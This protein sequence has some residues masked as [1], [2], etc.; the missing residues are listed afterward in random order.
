MKSVYL[1]I[2]FP[3][4]SSYLRSSLERW[5]TLSSSHPP[6]KKDIRL[7]FEK[8]HRDITDVWRF[9]DPDDVGDILGG[10]GFFERPHIYCLIF[11]Q[12]LRSA[13]F[14]RMILSLMQDLAKPESDLVL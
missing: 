9:E 3:C 10:H 13:S 1:N 2:E 11:I 8:L 14:K 12:V 4:F 7:C 6:D 5:R